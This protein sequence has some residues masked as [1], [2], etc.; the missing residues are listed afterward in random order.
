MRKFLHHLIFLLRGVTVYALIGSSG[1]GKSFRAKLIAQKHGIDY[2]I[3][4]GVLI[5]DN[6]IVAG[7]SAKKEKIYLKAIKTALFDDDEHRKEVAH[8][9]EKSRFKRILIIGTSQAMVKKIAKR[10]NL[11]IPTKIIRIEEIASKEEIEKAQYVRKTEGK[12]VIPVPSIEIKRNMPHIFYE[13]VKV[14]LRNR[15]LLRNK[16]RVF[17]KAVVRPEF[18]KRGK[19]TISETALSQMVLHCIDEYNTAIEVNKIVVIEERWGYKL[20]MD[21]SVPFGVEMAGAIHRLQEY[22]IENIERYTGILI[23]ELNI[24]IDKVST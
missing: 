17:E 15:F 6:K 8:Y 21:I 19:I 1:T 14:F 4:D 11:P 20:N 22:I 7:T 10:L 18:S 9:L 23:E 13:G 12:H 24:T 3:D 16:S 2:I 5:Y